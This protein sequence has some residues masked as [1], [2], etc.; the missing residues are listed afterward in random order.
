MGRWMGKT[1]I[2]T[3]ASSGIGAAVAEQ[4]VESGLK[5]RNCLG[6]SLYSVIL[7]ICFAILM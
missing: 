6:I 3:G 5:V 2:V 7:I 4:L 1:A